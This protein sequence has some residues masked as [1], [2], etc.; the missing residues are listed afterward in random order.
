MRVDRRGGHGAGDEPDVTSAAKRNRQIQASNRLSRKC[1]QT[2][3]SSF[4]HQI[5]VVDELG[6]VPGPIGAP[7]A[8]NADLA[9]DQ[10]RLVFEGDNQQADLGVHQ[11]PVRA[12]LPQAHLRAPGTIGQ[13]GH[14]E[15]D[16]FCRPLRLVGRDLA[17]ERVGHALGERDGHRQTEDCRNRNGPE[18][19]GEHEAG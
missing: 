6:T 7:G 16:R 15:V 2:A 1:W 12:V 10:R 8:S 11:Q 4:E 19:P 18:E 13:I 17:V 9:A 5:V 3:R 14:A